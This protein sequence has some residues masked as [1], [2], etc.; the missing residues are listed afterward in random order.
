MIPRIFRAHP[1]HLSGIALTDDVRQ[2]HEYAGLLYIETASG[3]V[4]A[5][6]PYIY[7]QAANTIPGDT[8]LEAGQFVFNWPY[9]SSEAASF[10]SAALAASD[11]ELND[12]PISFVADAN[13]R[14]FSVDL[15]AGMTD[16]HFYCG[17]GFHYFSVQP[18]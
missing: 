17:Y 18:T 4:T 16:L 2:I 1:I 11:F 5:T 3:L 12:S 7:L 6:T 8:Q 14:T 10:S 13:A 9:N 15:P